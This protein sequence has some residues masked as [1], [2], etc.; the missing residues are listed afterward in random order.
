[1]LNMEIKE[2]P[3]IRVATVRHV[4]PFEGLKPAFEK[5][6]GWGATAG[7]FGPDTLIIGMFHDDPRTT[8]AAELR[9]DAGVTVAD[10]V[11]PDADSGVVIGE[12]AAG[13][14]AVGV[15]KG[16]YEG[17][18]A[19]YDWIYSTWASESGQ[20]LAPATSY[21]IYLNDPTSV[22]P[23]EILTEIRIPLAGA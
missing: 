12:M 10:S 1:M 2:L 13:T 18:K 9:S 3:A 5:I 6:C 14:Y 19:A 4:G 20:T 16:P 23:S 22:D 7:V 17:L 15:M 8:P 11:T 21:E